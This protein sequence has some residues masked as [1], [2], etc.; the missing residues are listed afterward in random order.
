M[1]HG[2][3]ANKSSFHA[4]EFTTGLNVIVAERTSA[5][6][7][8]DTRNGLGKSSLIEIIDFCLGSSGMKGEGLCIEP[9]ADWAFTID[10]TIAGQRVK[11]TRATEAPKQI[12]ID[13]S[14]SGWIEQ[15]DI[16]KTTQRRLFSVE[17]W[18][19]VLGWAFFGLP[20]SEDV[21]K[22]KPSYRS[23]ISYFIRQGPDA[24]SDPFSH[25]RQQKTWDIQLHIGFL[26]GLNWEYAAQWQGFKDQKDAL[27]AISQ[28]IKTGAM[29]GALGS[30][31]ELEAERVQLETQVEREA[32]ALA[33][34][35][36]H[37]QYETVQ[38]EADRITAS[39]HGLTNQN[40]A[41]RRHL[42][43]YKESVADEKPPTDG[44]LELV[45]EETGLVFP[46]AVK[47]T[48]AEAKEFH[49]RIVENRKAFLETEIQRL[50]S[51][52]SERDGQ[53]KEQTDARALSLEV[54]RTHG[55]LQEMTMMQEK[56]L[57]AKGRLER[58]RS[59]IMEIKDNTSRKRDIRVA[60][61]EL[62]KIADR[63]HEQRREVWSKAVRLF[64][65]I[66][67]ALYKSPGCLVINI[68]ETGFKYGVE[69]ERSGS[70]GI[71]K[72]KVF[73]F[74]L[75]LLQLVPFMS[76]H[77]DFLIHDSVLY[78]GVD[79]R[80]RAL[81]IERAA[82]VTQAQG[83]QYI[84]TLNSDM[85]PREDFNTDFDFDRHVRLTLKDRD[86]SGSLLGFQFARPGK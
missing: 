38:Q 74:D 49:R 46:E 62:A 20:K 54:L 78:D 23:L 79:S 7:Q 4:V 6:T 42:A 13:G 59:R 57:E 56:H 17:R 3:S 69:I 30:V 14:T 24:Y 21:H 8:K 22:Y 40:V 52:I 50:E 44:A 84:C 77:I 76:R 70:E 68:T 81:A 33:N 34:F 48:L 18:R 45:Y 19:Q 67:Q 55:A 82:Q 35:K 58:V 47:R 64:N 61:E 80:Q 1:I 32:R 53:I 63:D 16:D 41:A 15:P 11:A 43:R 9:L 39:I 72:M 31:G 83:T 65:E 51:V 66:S 71:G 75:M 12:V 29:E 10:I 60:K 27:T 86:P 36:V 2:I 5:S 73:C 25:Y 26:L 85:I 28:A 37:P